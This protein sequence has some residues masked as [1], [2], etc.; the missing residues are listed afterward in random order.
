MGIAVFIAC[1]KF[2]AIPLKCD[3]A[4]D[5]CVAKGNWKKYHCGGSYAIN[6]W[7]LFVVCQRRRRRGRKR[8]EDERREMKSRGRLFVCGPSPVSMMKQSS[9]RLMSGVCVQQALFW[10]T[11]TRRA[12]RAR[13][14]ILEP[15]RGPAGAHSQLL[16]IHWFSLAQLTTTWLWLIALC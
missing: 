10:Q 6:A 15:F 16:S 11:T 2:V 3:T 8:I 5:I 14:V 12:L 9:S 7:A 4:A 13:R 1:G